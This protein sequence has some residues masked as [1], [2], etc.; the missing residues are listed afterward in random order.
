MSTK[1]GSI[2]FIDGN[3]SPNDAEK[4]AAAIREF[5][6]EPSEPVFVA[7]SPPPRAVTVP[8]GWQLVPIEPTYQM[9]EAIGL[10]WEHPPFPLR[11]ARMIAAAP[12]LTNEP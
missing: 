8:D 4:L 2:Q 6:S 3:I 7:A 10:P 12:K 11:Y 1:P 5:N 9:S